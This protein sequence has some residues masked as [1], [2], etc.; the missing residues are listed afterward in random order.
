VDMIILTERVKYAEAAYR[1]VHWLCEDSGT[2]LFDMYGLDEIEVHRDI[3]K[4]TGLR[5]DQWLDLTKPYDAVCFEVM[6]TFF[7][8]PAGGD[9]FIA[10]PRFEKLYRDLR[11]AKKD[12]F[13]SMR[14]SYPEEPQ[15]KAVADF[16]GVGT[17]DSCIIKREGED[18][19]FRKLKDMLPGKKILYIG[20]G[21]VNECIVPRYYGIDTYR[22]VPI[23]YDCLAPIVPEELRSSD[24]DE[25]FEGRVKE[26]IEKA[27]VISF[28]IF[29][30]VLHRSLPAPSDVFVMMEQGGG[31]PEGFAHDRV[32]AE[33]SLVN[34]D[35]FEIYE[36]LGRRLG[37]DKA[38][39]DR[40]REFEFETEKTVLK[41]RG[42]VAGLIE[43]ARGKGKTV[44]LTSDMYYPEALMRELLDDTGITG[45]E[46]VFVS[47]DYKKNKMSGLFD[48]VRQFAEDFVSGSGIAEGNEPAILH[49]GDNRT[50]DKDAAKA[51]GM[52]AVHIPAAIETAMTH[53]WDVSVYKAS[54]FSEKSLVGLAVSKAFADPF[55]T[56]D[57]MELGMRDRLV[58]YADSV[59]GP[60]TSGFITWIVS[61]LHEEPD[62]D[63]V[64]FFA[65][66][67]YLPYLVYRHVAEHMELPPAYYFYSSRKASFH[68]V[69]DMD[70]QIERAVDLGKQF[71]LAADE[72]LEKI[73]DIK[74]E[75]I[76]PMEEDELTASFIRKQSA[77][78][79]R[80]AEMARTG[81]LK[82]AA[83]LGMKEGGKYLVT[84]FISSGTTYK[85]LLW[86][87]YE[88]K[89]VFFGTRNETEAAKYKF[90]WYLRGENDTLMRNYVELE[91]Y[92]CSPE[93]SMTMISEE[94]E[95]VFAEERRTPEELEEFKLVAERT[96][97]FAEEYFDKLNKKAELVRPAIPEE[98]FA[99]D[100]FHDVQRVAYEDWGG[101]TIR[102]RAYDR[103]NFIK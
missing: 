27:D 15:R 31:V 69:E 3:D 82:Y 53:G 24:F 83:G 4:C 87:P 91:S 21:L 54:G 5:Q 50:A 98:M 18:L 28:D 41:V 71:G 42:P 94:G 79:S 74:G 20:T 19:S 101:K 52:D 48:E 14:K 22:A 46:A 38:E 67:G 2:K 12:V 16:A 75:N 65:R 30:T 56:P 17:D 81:Y 43:Y 37:L 61:L 66:D 9:R 96:L 55:R 100:G 49:I 29:D 36:E 33:L 89:G 76:I 84:D 103:F 44:V 95:P 64:L 92:Y 73:F 34:P 90:D 10:R 70:E 51:A 11:E 60:L 88:L 6:D 72:M 86:M 68:T 45:Y 85:Q 1:E 8:P 63:G 26:A 39:A 7:F 99:A 32:A 13:F 40:L 97:A 77:E 57:M 80:R 62:Y 25:G 35:I 102:S 78:R 59:V 47:C 58:R 93:P 23:L